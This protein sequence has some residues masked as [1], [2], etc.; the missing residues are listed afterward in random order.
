MENGAYIGL[1]RQMVLRTGM[2]LVANNIA[3]A[4]TPGY[5]TQTPLFAEHLADPKGGREVISMVTDYGQFDSTKEGPMR[6]TGGELDVALNGPG[7]FGVNGPE[8]LQYT[9]AGNFTMNNE[10]ELITASG[11]LVADTGGG[12][13]NIPEDA[14]EIKIDREGRVSTEQGEVGQIMVREFTNPQ[15][16]S[17][18]GS[19]L[20]ASADEG[21]PPENTQVFQGQLEGSNVQP[22]FEMTRMIEISREYQALQRFMQSDHDLQRTAIQRLGRPA[23]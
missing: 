18:S 4:S 19:G 3:N 8:G 20:Y 6:M 17:P 12:A 16:L 14:K 2:D 22:V 5:R 10:R 21:I 15:M 13:I 7:F 9:R 23:G 1:S 11:Y